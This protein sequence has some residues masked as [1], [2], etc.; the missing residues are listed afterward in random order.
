V[1]RLHFTETTINNLRKKGK[2]NPEQRFFLLVSGIY[3][4]SAGAQPV[5]YPVI[6]M[7][8][9]KIIVRASNP[10]QFES[11]IEIPWHKS[12]GIESIYHYVSVSEYASK[13]ITN[14]HDTDY[15]TN[16]RSMPCSE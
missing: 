5:Q 11:D 3:A 14:L 6:E 10:G 12:G 7:T 13:P 9:E 8:S 2:P 4:H 15:Y 16:T 1:G